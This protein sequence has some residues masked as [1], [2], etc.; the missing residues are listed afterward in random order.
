MSCT[1]SGTFLNPDASVVANGTLIL[2]LSQNAVENP[3]GWV[4]PQVVSITLNSSGA[5]PAATTIIGNDS[6]T[7][8]GTTYTVQIVTAALVYYNLG[9]FSITGATFN[10]NTATPSGGGV[11]YPFPVLQNPTS[12]QT[13]TGQP[14]TLT[15][16]APLTAAS[17]TIG[18]LQGV[19]VFAD[20]QTGADNSEKILNAIG[21]LPSVGG[22]VDARALPTETSGGGSKSIDPGTKSVTILLGPV[23]YR[24]PQIKLQSNLRIYGSGMGNQASS[25]NT[26]IIQ[27]TSG[28]T[29]AFILG[30]NQAVQGVVLEGFRLYG[31][32]GN[33]TQKGLSITGAAGGGLWY[34]SFRNLYIGATA[35]NDHF[36][37]GNMYFNGPHANANAINQ[38]LDF[39]NVQSIR[40]S[41]TGHCLDIIGFNGQFL[42]DQCEFDGNSVNDGGT[43]INIADDSTSLPFSI[44]FELP[45][46]QKASIGVQVRGSWNI[47]FNGCHVENMG[48]V[49]NLAAGANN[50][51]GFSITNSVFQTSGQNSGSGYYVQDTA[52]L[53][54][55]NFSNN[56]MSLVAD[57]WP[58]TL[59][60]SGNM[61]GVVPYPAANQL[62]NVKINAQSFTSSGTFSVPKG[63]NTVKV[64]V[65]GGGGGGGGS[66]STNN[67]GGGAAGGYSETF[68]TNL[69]PVL[70]GVVTQGATITVTVGT[71]GA[72]GTGAATGSAGGASSVAQNTVATFTTIAVNGGAGGFSTGAAS[73]GAGAT[74][75]GTGGSVNEGGN[76]GMP[77]M[78]GIGGAGGGSVFGGGA[79][80]TGA[81][82]FAGSNGT[83][84]GAGGAGASSGSSQAGG[85]GVAG[86][87]IFEWIS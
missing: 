13:I 49:F 75:L 3:T 11:T 46:I 9:S 62:S 31:V 2:T 14:L 40:N 20:Q 58:A 54:S 82:G 4:V 34:S 73:P 22:I 50:N 77:G 25:V 44:M 59:I 78:S 76:P 33:S 28:T 17:V 64:R 7:P 16:S 26:T 24:I 87:V 51:I 56:F 42:F 36:R 84:H 74:A 19:V 83:S 69:S 39:T 60:G 35:T 1:I 30:S 79:G 72:G 80:C 32:S 45:T 10:F 27:T 67:G 38:F 66:T 18:E 15:N 8:A 47:T 29:D 53:N 6:L 43:N 65:V 57:N 68:L 21:A 37:G 86:I 48:G 71:G 5:I 23:T 81:G 41:S 70:T 61:Q 52:A 63:V 12:A 55:I 85:S